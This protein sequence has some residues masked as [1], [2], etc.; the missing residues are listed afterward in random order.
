MYVHHSSNPHLILLDEYP[1]CN[2]RL[3]KPGGLWI[4]DESEL[5]WATWCEREEF[6]LRPYKYSVELLED[7]N[8]LWLKTEQETIDFDNKY[9]IQPFPGSRLTMVDW[10]RVQREYQGIMV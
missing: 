7:A 2:R 3:F 10:D 5:S 8:L 9:S 4:S 6:G 1:Y